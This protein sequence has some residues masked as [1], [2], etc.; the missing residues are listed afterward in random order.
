MKLACENTKNGVAEE[1]CKMARAARR[2]DK[3]R[4]RAVVAAVK[5][6]LSPAQAKEFLNAVEDVAGKVARQG[7]RWHAR[8]GPLSVPVEAFERMRTNAR[9]ATDDAW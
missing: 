3:L 6:V 4:W 2:A 5:E 8:A 9:A 7:T 1:M